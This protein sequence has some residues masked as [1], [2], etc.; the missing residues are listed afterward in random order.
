MAT[1]NLGKIRPTFGGDWDSATTY[2][3]LTY[4]RYLNGY[5]ISKTS[6]VNA[7][8]STNP[9]KWDLITS[10]ELSILNVQSLTDTTKTYSAKYIENN[11][12]RL[13]R[14]IDP[15]QIPD[16]LITYDMIAY[17]VVTTIDNKVAKVPG[18]T[19]NHF[20]RGDGSVS[21]KVILSGRLLASYDCYDKSGIVKFDTTNFKQGSID[22]EENTGNIVVPAGFYNLSVSLGLE[23]EDKRSETND[24]IVVH[25]YNVTT[26][27]IVK[28][29]SVNTVENTITSVNI[30]DI[31][32]GNQTYCVKIEYNGDKVRIIGDSVTSPTPG[33][34]KSIYTKFSI[35]QID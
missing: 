23:T 28:S 21:Y 32:P 5:Y 31:V 16:G 3:E 27:T 24:T 18:A 14:T 12:N 6:S 2:T 9:D 8:P 26:D 29:T 22:L 17:D 19:S 25:I 11:F 1:I 34:N 10:P 7:N 4:V 30:Q 35:S 13:N 20:Y 15:G 33:N